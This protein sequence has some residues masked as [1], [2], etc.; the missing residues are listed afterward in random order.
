MDSQ[1]PRREGPAPLEREKGRE[2]GFSELGSVRW[3]SL[4]EEQERYPLHHVAR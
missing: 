2:E 3:E 4:F 1:D